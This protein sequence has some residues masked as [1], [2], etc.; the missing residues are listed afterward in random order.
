LILGLSSEINLLTKMISVN[1]R[2]P[3]EIGAKLTTLFSAAKKE[4]KQIQET[5][6]QPELTLKTRLTAHVR[7]DEVSGV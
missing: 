5:N 2:K 6:P 4:L 7:P 3:E 1:E